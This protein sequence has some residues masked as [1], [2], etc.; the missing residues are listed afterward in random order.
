MQQ[1]V[2]E[3]QIARIKSYHCR[4]EMVSNR[5]CNTVGKEA[6]SHADADKTGVSR[7]L[8]DNA[9]GVTR[10]LSDDRKSRV[11]PVD[12]RADLAILMR[13]AACRW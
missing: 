4:P 12:T 5:C 11:E 1:I 2:D 3:F 7:D 13:S 9:D 8:A 10:R 6:G